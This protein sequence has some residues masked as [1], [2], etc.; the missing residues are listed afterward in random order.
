MSK[1]SK[2]VQRVWVNRE[3]SGKECSVLHE[4]VELWFSSLFSLPWDQ[5]TFLGY[6]AEIICIVVTDEGYLLTSGA[7]L[8]LYI[9]MCLHLRAF[10]E[11]FQ[12]LLRER[13]RPNRVE[14][15]EEFIC[16]VIRFHNSV[17]R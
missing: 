4:N 9:S 14:N 17:K 1:N 15:S 12:H 5:E 8:L 2:D 13:E 10:Y 6:V 7:V 11:M 16:D 3:A